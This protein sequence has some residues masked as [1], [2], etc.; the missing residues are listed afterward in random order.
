MSA[1]LWAL[2]HAVR[3]HIVI[4]GHSPAIPGVPVWRCSRCGLVRQAI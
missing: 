1:L 2:G 4:P 3:G